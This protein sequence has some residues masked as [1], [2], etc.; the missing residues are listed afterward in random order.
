MSCFK[1]V[2]LKPHAVPR[3]TYHFGRLTE[4]PCDQQK[5]VKVVT[6]RARGESG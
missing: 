3:L 1:R 6:H 2:L 4:N 5:E